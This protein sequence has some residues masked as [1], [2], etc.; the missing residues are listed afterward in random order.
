MP[1]L[2]PLLRRP[3]RGARPLFVALLSLVAA[4]VLAQQPK[5]NIILLF[6]DD[7]GYADFEFMNPLVGETTEFKTP[8]LNAFAAQSRLM[9][10]GYVAVPVCSASRAG[11]LTGRQG[12][13]FEYNVSN[14]NDPRDGMP[15]GEVMMQEALKQAG[16]KTGA[17]GKWHIGAE[18]V[19][20]PG[21]Q[22]F[23]EFYGILAGGRPYFAT[24]GVPVLRNTTSIAWQNEA[25]F[26]NI[27]PDP[28]LG[29]H[30]T[31]AIGDEASKFVANNA[32]QAQPFFMYVPFTAPHAPYD[33]AKAQDLALF[34]STSLTGI[35]KNVAAL[36]YAMDRAVGN[37]IARVNDPNGDGN[38]DDSIADNTIIVFAN[39]NGGEQP[40]PSYGNVAGH[41]NGPLLRWKG[42]AWEG[43]IRVPMIVNMPGGGTGVYNEMVSTL[44]LMPTFLAAAGVPLPNNLHGENLAPFLSGQQTGPVHD[45]LF[46]RGGSNYWAMRKGNWKLVHGSQTA[47]FQLYLL[48]P[49]GSGEDPALSHNNSDRPVFEAMLK[50]FVDWE[51]TQSKP[52]HTT[53]FALNR[54]DAFRFRQDIA[55]TNSW[56]NGSVWANDA[57]PASFTAMNRED[58]YANAALVFQPRNDASYTSDNNISRSTGL[59][60]GAIDSGQRNPAGL[61]EFMLNELRF[62]G[63]FNGAAAQSGTLT[64]FP[65]MFVKSLAG[66]TPTIKLQTTSSVANS[67][68]FNVNMAVVLHS[69]LEI[70]GN[71]SQPF[72]INGQIRD[73]DEARSIIKT[74]TSSIALTANN[75]YAGATV[76][77]GGA[78]R[79]EGASAVLLNT[80]R[81]D[82]GAQ[83]TFTFAGSRVRTPQVNVAPGGVFNFNSGTLETSSFAGD[84]T[85]NGG[86]LRAAGQ[87]P[88]MMLISGDYTQNIGTTSIELG[89]LSAGTQYDQIRIGGDAMLKAALNVSLVNPFSPTVGSSFE[90]LHAD[91]LVNGTFNSVNVPALTDN[92]RWAVQYG[93]QSVWLHVVNDLAADFDNNGIVNAADLGVWRSAQGA[94]AA[95]DADGDGDTDGNDFIAWQRQMNTRLLASSLMAIPE[96]TAA[97]LALLALLGLRSAPFRSR[98]GARRIV[99]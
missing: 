91:G 13:G 77:N 86:N 59:Y 10:N 3:S 94:T 99:G 53:S 75:I 98:R 48:N 83:G 49:D 70:T 84:L 62:D 51:A 64:G 34:D 29:R 85:N 31:D 40:L 11:M 1:R 8:N 66:V 52:L 65:L 38:Q 93:S 39:D 20:Q 47:G 43:G 78:L 15:V 9:S 82:V 71:S 24:G 18:T 21:N 36:T 54:F 14:A 2:C 67:F 73:F 28:T 92:R 32:N 76:V 41:D 25:S 63:A 72:A 50:E 19:K 35:R 17:F 90:I 89:G 22:G 79:V 37:I 74:G 69:D 61:E 42:T 95:G 23:D 46:W 7:A 55:T 88:G 16:Y 57:D 80:S 27:P 87:T 26:N 6:A 4:P 97:T 58:S 68:T 56:R 96:P 12:F 44:D 60:Y 45:A 33:A 30:F 5:P 81:I